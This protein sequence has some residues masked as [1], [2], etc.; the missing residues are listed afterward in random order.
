MALMALSE[1]RSRGQNRRLT[2]S[3]CRFVGKSWHPSDPVRFR[4]QA[5]YSGNATPGTKYDDPDSQAITQPNS[6]ARSPH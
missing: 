3:H 2:C 6:G 5:F 1:F 4:S